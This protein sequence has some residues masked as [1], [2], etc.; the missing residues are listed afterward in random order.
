MTS[1]IVIGA[2]SCGGGNSG[3][4]DTDPTSPI[5]PTT[6]TDIWKE[7]VGDYSN[8]TSRKYFD[9]GL[10]NEASNPNYLYENTR[11]N[12][13]KENFIKIKGDSILFSGLKD[14]HL[15]FAIYNK[16]TKKCILDWEDKSIFYNK[17]DLGYGNY[18]TCTELLPRYYIKTT[19]GDIVSFMS[20]NTG[21]LQY[22]TTAFTSNNKSV[23]VPGLFISK[24]YK[25]SIIINRKH[26]SLY[27]DTL[28]F[29]KED[30]NLILK[31]GRFNFGSYQFF[32]PY[33]YSQMVI[34][35]KIYGYESNFS[36]YSI[37]FVKGDKRQEILAPFQIPANA[38]PKYTYTLLDNSTNLWKFKV[39][40]IYVDGT[41]KEFTFTFNIDTGE[42]KAT[43]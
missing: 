42:Y 24:W 20:N 17:F 22:S 15:W 7:Y 28:F 26:I 32:M 29:Y 3:T 18:A 1:L 23:D 40:M 21:D 31:E 35:T 33:S 16:K 10:A 11:E 4:T 34:I 38:N 41:K 37:D 19:N 14:K 43:E 8:I 27:T 5:E 25:E 9:E 2:Y 39:N 13:P 36:I 12:L 30:G 6:P